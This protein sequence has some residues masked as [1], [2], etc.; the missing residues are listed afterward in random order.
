MEVTTRQGPP[1]GV[2]LADSA[3]GAAAAISATLAAAA[4]AR[5][6]ISGFVVTGGGATAG[7][8]VVV[9]VTGPAVTLSFDVAV[10]AGVLLGIAALVVTFLIPIPA[11]ADNTA[12]VVA[13]PSLG[14]GNTSAAVTAWGIRQ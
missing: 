11:S 9:T 1:V 8:V 4:G 12:I 10:P 5:T 2:V 7:S 6:S 3:T 13:V 14:A